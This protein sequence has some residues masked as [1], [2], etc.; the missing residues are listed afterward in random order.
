MKIKNF[1]KGMF[2][3][4]IIISAI[5]SLAMYEICSKLLK[6]F[7]ENRIIYF[8]SLVVA[9]LLLQSLFK[10]IKSKLKKQNEIKV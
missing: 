5:T 7:I 3:K 6:L 4:D 8:I 2:E 9:M 1:I 10:F